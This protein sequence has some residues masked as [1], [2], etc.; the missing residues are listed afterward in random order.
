MIIKNNL[1]SLRQ[2]RDLKQAALAEISDVSIT[3]ISDI[4]MDKHCPSVYIAL[5]LAK[6]LEVPVEAI[7]W[8]EED[9]HANEY[10]R[11][12]YQRVP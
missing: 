6:A 1:K 3:T 4:E 12:T 2:E 8:I 5:K 11:C 9:A 7:F 10:R